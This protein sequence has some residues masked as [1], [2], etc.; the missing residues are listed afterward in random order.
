MNSTNQFSENRCVIS[1]NQLD[2]TNYSSTPEVFTTE[3]QSS[4]TGSNIT[5]VGFDELVSYSYSLPNSINIFKK[6]DLSI[7]KNHFV[8]KQVN[9]FYSRFHLLLSYFKKYIPETTSLPY[10][11]L[12]Q[13]DEDESV[14]IEWIFKDFR[15]GFSFGKEER[16]S[17]WYFVANEK[18]DSI[19]TSGRI[20]DKVIDELLINVIK[21]VISNV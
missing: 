15:I 9:K 21:F 20:T 19:S 18:F 6:I 8:R 12:A 3:Q 11:M 2:G 16:L 14:L 10:L 1:G 13:D 4:I 17:S 7:I 5:T